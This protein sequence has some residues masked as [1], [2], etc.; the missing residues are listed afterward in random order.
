MS[1]VD[2]CPAEGLPTK[3]AQFLGWVVGLLS[4]GLIGKTVQ[5]FE[6]DKDGNLVLVWLVYAISSVIRAGKVSSLCAN[7]EGSQS[8]GGCRVW[9]PGG[10]HESW[11]ICDQDNLKILAWCFYV[12]LG[13]S[14]SSRWQGD[15]PVFRGES[16]RQNFSKMTKCVNDRKKHNLSCK[17]TLTWLDDKTTQNI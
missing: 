11:L 10:H 1:W 2:C 13:D 4:G 15:G 16:S 6:G 3:T 12:V 9:L 8:R 5:F 17:H 14:Q 7:F